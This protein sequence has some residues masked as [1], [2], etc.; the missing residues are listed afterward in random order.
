MSSWIVKPSDAF[1]QII[2]TEVANMSDELR[3]HGDTIEIDNPKVLRWCRRAYGAAA[4]YARRPFELQSQSDIIRGYDGREKLRV[5]PVSAVSAVRI[6][7]ADTDVT[8][9]YYELDGD[10]LV[11]SSYDTLYYVTDDQDSSDKIDI[12]VTYAGGFVLPDE[13]ETL[14]SA[15]AMQA[16][17]WFQQKELLGVRAVSI[18]Q[19]S[20]SSAHDG[21]RLNP[22]VK[23]M[24][25]IFRYY[26]NGEPC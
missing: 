19:G 17:I 23:E 10:Y 9:T 18:P 1:I 26:G 22:E 7:G 13:D 3:E 12:K 5:T 14:L 16:A 8:A 15:L 25:H 20:I 4:R 24:L 11:M 2:A 21:V 6:I